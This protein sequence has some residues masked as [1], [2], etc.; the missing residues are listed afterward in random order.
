[1]KVGRFI[2]RFVAKFA[3]IRLEQRE[4]KRSAR[5]ESKMLKMIGLSCIVADIERL[6]LLRSGVFNM[7]KLIRYLSSPF[8][9]IPLGQ[10]YRKYGDNR[11]EY[12]VRTRLPLRRYILEVFDTRT[13]QKFRSEVLGHAAIVG[14]FSKV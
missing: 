1:M 12:V 9:S 3:M 10:L 4:K 8:V 13:R 7:F 5:P 14:N 11:F 6:K 2:A